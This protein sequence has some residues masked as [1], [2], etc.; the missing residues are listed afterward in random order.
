MLFATKN[1]NNINDYVRDT[2]RQWDKGINEDRININ[3][4]QKYKYYV[5]CSRNQNNF[6]ISSWNK[7]N[8]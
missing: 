2:K 3:S 5:H 8:K 4:Y 6:I 1:T 7:I